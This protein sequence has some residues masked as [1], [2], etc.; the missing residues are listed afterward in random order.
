MRLLF[1]FLVL[2]KEMTINPKDFKS[3]S[4]KYFELN[5]L[6]NNENYFVKSTIYT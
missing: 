1:I 3:I 6:N 5:K 2:S 4:V